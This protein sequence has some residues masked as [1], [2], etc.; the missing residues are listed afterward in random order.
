MP[1]TFRH[2]AINA[3]D[4]ERAR[5][6]YEKTFDWTFTPWGPPEYYQIHG[7]GGPGHIGALQKRRE[8]ING[9]KTIAFETTI[10]VDDLDLAMSVVKANGGRILFAP[11]RIE[12]VGDLTYLEDP[13]GNVCGMAQYLPGRWP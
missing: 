7:S 6:F 3:D 2:F 1:G 13:E 8:L 12:G 9:Q 11:F 10:G 4:V 5:A